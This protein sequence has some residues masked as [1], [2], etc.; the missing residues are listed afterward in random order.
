MAANY[1]SLEA[2]S[3]GAVSIMAALAIGATLILGLAWLVT[4]YLRRNS[5]AV[6]YCVWQLTVAGL[7]VLPLFYAILPGWSVA[8]PLPFLPAQV[9]Q[10]S[11][12]S[13]AFDSGEL[14]A[15][16]ASMPGI[17][18]SFIEP[19]LADQT[20][21]ST[22]ESIGLPRLEKMPAT[23]T[24]QGPA[25]FVAA[26]SPAMV[27]A[28]PASWPTFVVIIWLVGMSVNLLW[29]AV[30]LYRARRLLRGSQPIE[31]QRIIAWLNEL[32]KR[33][34]K[35][36]AIRLL[37]TP[38]MRVP[39]VV[40][41]LRATILLPED[42]T[43]W[44]D[45]Q[46][47]VVLSHELAH[48]YR[49]DI[50]WQLSS[51]LTAAFYWMHPLVWLAVRRMR[52]ERERACD[53]HVLRLGVQAADYA[54]GLIEVAAALTGRSVRFVSG[55]GMADRGQLEDRVRSILDESTT[56]TPVSTWVRRGIFLATTCVVLAVGMLRPFNPVSGGAEETPA[57]ESQPQAEA[58]PP[59]AKATSSAEADPKIP[60]P[61]F[62]D[63][64]N[65]VPTKGSMRIRVVGTDNQPRAG[66]KI[67]INVGT[68]EDFKSNR[69]Y[70]CDADGQV[71][72][73]LPATLRL[74]RIW[75]RE[76]SY[77]PMFAQWWPKE[78]ADGA[79]IPEEFTFRM[80]KGTVMGG[81]VKD[82]DGN[83]IPGVRVDVTYEGKGIK[84]VEQRAIFD[85]WL[86][87]KD[88]LRVTDAEGRWTLDNVP[89][90]DDVDVRVIATHPDFISLHSYSESRLEKPLPIKELRAQTSTIVIKR[91]IRLTGTITDPQG[92]P[93]V[94]ALAIWGD[95]PFWEHNPQ[96]EVLT[97]DQGVYRL[98]PLPAGPMRVTVVAQGWM[99]D[100]RKV[101]FTPN[102]GP[103]D[104]HLKA[105][106]TLR[107]RLVDVDG[108][109]VSKANFRVEKWRGAESLY[110]DKHSNVLDSKIPR[111]PGANGVYEWTWAPD[112][113][114]T[115]HVSA[116]GDFCTPEVNFTAD[117][118][119]QVFKLL[120]L[121]R[122]GGSV[123]DARTGQPIDRFTV[124][125]VLE[126]N[127][128]LF[129]VERQQAREYSAGHYILER[130]DR[131]DVAYR[132][133]VEA[134]GYRTA[135]SEPFRVGDARPTFDVRLDPAPLARGRVVDEKGT[136]VAGV[137]VFLAT[138]TQGLN[139]AQNKEEEWND[140]Y[141]TMTNDRGEFVFP[142]QFEPY[143]VIATHDSG[144]AELALQAS[145]LPG[146]LVL[147]KWARVEGRLLQASRPVDAAHVRLWPL[148]PRFGD[149]PYVDQQFY[150]TTDE[151]GRFVFPEVPPV[152]CSVSAD[153]SPWQEYPITSS[154]HVPLDLQPGQ[155]VTLNL[156]GDGI[157]VTGRVVLDGDAAPD[158]DLNYSLNWL[159]RKAPGIE[160]PDEIR[161]IGFDWRRGW[162]DAWM[163]TQEGM[164]YCSTLHHYFV[165]LN[166][167]G[168]FLISGV[169]AGDYELAFKIYERPEGCLVSPVGTKTINF[170][171]TEPD[172]VKGGLDLGT[173]G[174]AAALGPKVG[175]LVPDFEFDTLHDGK[176]KLSELRGRYVLLNFWATWCG[177]CVASLP[178]VQELHDKHGAGR[179]LVLGLN[180]DA[181]IETARRFS[182]EH[183]LS[184]MQGFLGDDA[185]VPTRLGIS[186]TPTYVL[187]APDGKLL[188]KGFSSET[189]VE[190]VEAALSEPK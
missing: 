148:R 3:A 20:S 118:Q 183:R 186:S 169:P 149:L 111:N 59:E 136:A 139:I 179:L 134:A 42:C 2:L 109:P 69:D 155:Q 167:D 120:P 10:N 67:H 14:T 112:D 121:L 125:P 160:P 33:Q 12:R 113:A 7:L 78:Q 95:R 6:R 97:D 46:L 86:A 126:F 50:F 15:H 158:I 93:V 9:N 92:K 60:E 68:K 64:P 36:V 28:T 32:Q 166:R 24:A 137:R 132:V 16:V 52:I 103:L 58:K 181:D 13:V 77:A 153:L 66:S 79:V 164:T 147:K 55:I 171:V 107:I 71:D 188:H 35:H 106:K 34:A 101:E 8:I 74:L 30:C 128:N 38:R 168:T 80:Q 129:H 119:E 61:P 177:P 100:M 17:H 63:R 39:M 150:C 127:S 117:D 45:E 124:V 21:A 162:S 175:E 154:Q 23:T 72:I 83:P 184:W 94:G 89:P 174:I 85:A 140:N 131:T 43:N 73:A 114:V 62:K 116:D 82:E 49:G 48:V 133:R 54:A 87:Y 26:S 91:G 138:K 81:F 57:A 180:L 135:M 31:E 4:C 53:D 122:I 18:E 29:L 98:P 157:Q 182:S 143:I 185:Q 165:R 22:N 90:G 56:R 130:L 115:F 1:E 123:T 108:A 96:Q 189:L 76:A 65:E 110:N 25:E 190:Q 88:D 84:A 5:A 104:F 173:V 99:P 163:N 47:R 141:K 70:T 142:A 187:I 172:V 11:E 75:A 41:V 151:T 144:Y 176:Q 178:I 159:L 156:G 170:Q 152:K 40:G 145:Q 105:G 44:S 19:G 51:R 102:I 161:D 37:T 146:D 27:S